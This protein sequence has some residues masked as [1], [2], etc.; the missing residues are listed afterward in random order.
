MRLHG[1]E[2]LRTVACLHRVRVEDPWL[3][4]SG[5]HGSNQE[6][7]VTGAHFK[8][9]ER[10]VTV[11]VTAQHLDYCYRDLS[12]FVISGHFVCL[13]YSTTQEEALLY[14]WYRGKQSR[15]L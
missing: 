8:H 6:E 1:R 5:R 4:L 3:K 2:Y 13:L 9:L 14:P 11:T 15:F 12:L 7:E 10:A